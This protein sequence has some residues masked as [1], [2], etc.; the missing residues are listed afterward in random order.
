MTVKEILK[1]WLE[2]HGYDGL[3]IDGCY[4]GC[5]LCDLF[6]CCDKGMNCQPGH[7]RMGDDGDWRIFAD[8]K[9]EVKDD[10]GH[11]IGPTAGPTQ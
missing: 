7:K 5:F 1:A 9:G 4:Y 10:I 8:T 3:C 6:P 11:D 2:E